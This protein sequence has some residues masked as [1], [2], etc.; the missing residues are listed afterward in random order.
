MRD[1]YGLHPQISSEGLERQGDALTAADAERY[2]ASPDAIALHAVQQ[3]RR[4]N[5]TGRAD[6]VS[7]CDR[8]AFD[9]DDILG[10]TEFLNDGQDDG[11]KRLVDLEALHVP[12][13][14]TRP[15]EGPL[16]GR[17][18]AQ[19]KQSR[20]NRTDSE[21]GKTRHRLEPPLLRPGHVCDDHCRSAG[22]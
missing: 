16:H 15:V 10:K 19:S 4:Q 6:G 3:T 5:G 21:A 8:S 13:L 2:D 22:V 20:L 9:V 12:E 18:R 14:P 7:M 1:H 17:D 11:G